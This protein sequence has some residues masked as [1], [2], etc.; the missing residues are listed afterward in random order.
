[1]HCAVLRFEISNH[2]VTERGRVYTLKTGQLR[3]VVARKPAAQLSS[4]FR[5]MM[6]R[7]RQSWDHDSRSGHVSEA[8]NA[9]C[10]GIK[11]KSPAQAEFARSCSEDQTCKSLRAASAC[12]EEGLYLKM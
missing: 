1:M 12:A 4:L 7:I 9:S 6:F 10:E 5:G 2:R 11:I 8:I 3:F